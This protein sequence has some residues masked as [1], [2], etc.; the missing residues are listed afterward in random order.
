M[1]SCCF[2]VFLLYHHCYNPQWLLFCLLTASLQSFV[3]YL[4]LPLS[5]QKL[6]WNYYITY[7]PND[8]DRNGVRK[9]FPTNLG[10]MNFPKGALMQ[11]WKSANIFA[12]MWKH[13]IEDFTL[14]H[15][16]IFEICTREICENIVYK[17]SEA[18]EYVKN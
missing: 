8:E 6:N 5:Y 11:I 9:R 2:W 15:L 12:F 16:L 7:S 4:S 3:F 10:K 17:H 14:R 18:I 1:A 13:Y